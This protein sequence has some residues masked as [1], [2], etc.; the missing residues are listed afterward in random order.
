MPY[1]LGYHT[2]HLG[3]H[4]TAPIHPMATAEY[5]YPVQYPWSYETHHFESLG[6]HMRQQHQH[7]HRL[8]M[9]LHEQPG[10]SS[11]TEDFL[12]PQGS[13]AVDVVQPQDLSQLSHTQQAISESNTPSDIIKE[14]SILS[15]D[16]TPSSSCLPKLPD[17]PITTSNASLPP[18]PCLQHFPNPGSIHHQHQGQHPFSHHP[19]GLTPEHIPHGAPIHLHPHPAAFPYGFG[20]SLS[21]TMHMW[22]RPPMQLTA[23]QPIAGMHSSH[24]R[25]YLSPYG[26]WCHHQPLSQHINPNI[27]QNPSGDGHQNRE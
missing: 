7:Q 23:M 5:S 14:P 4:I 12:Q 19:R 9:S 21:S 6:D 2:H 17:A 1:S 25:P 22:Q 15:P 10:T 27:R 8:A 11:T 18:S 20:P 3:S 26:F 16:F 13:R 24:L